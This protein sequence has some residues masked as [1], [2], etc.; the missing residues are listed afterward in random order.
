MKH[1]GTLYP[2]PLPKGDVTANITWRKV[3]GEADDVVRKP[4]AVIQNS[5]KPV[6]AKV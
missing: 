4:S 2:P 1:K 6:K 3:A 5:H